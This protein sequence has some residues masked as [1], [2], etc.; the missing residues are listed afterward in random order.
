[1]RLNMP[2]FPVVNG[3]EVTNN[4]RGAADLLL[5][6]DES[7]FGRLDHIFVRYYVRMG[8]P[9]APQVSDRKLILS[10]GVPRWT[11]MGG[12]MGIGPSHATSYGGV[13]GSSG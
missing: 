6:M 4:G 8:T 2:S 3:Q 10:N 11:D 7:N 5:F 9:Y 13:S 1:M 12:K